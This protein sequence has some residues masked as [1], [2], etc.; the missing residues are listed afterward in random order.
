LDH[1]RAIWSK[2]R[3]HMLFLQHR[4]RNSEIILNNSR[5]IKFK[6]KIEDEEVIVASSKDEIY[7][8]H[9]SNRQIDL[10]GSG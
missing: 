6:M 5:K 4:D 9:D 3:I 10:Y 1:E 7:Q 2:G 8:Q